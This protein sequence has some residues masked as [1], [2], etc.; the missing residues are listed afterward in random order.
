MQQLIAT[1]SNTHCIRAH[2]CV[3]ECTHTHMHT[4][5]HTHR[6]GD[7]KVK[8]HYTRML[9]LLCNVFGLLDTA[10]VPIPM[11]P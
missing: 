11:A 9:K 4:R 3:Y 8:G 2:A 6:A 1:Y 5:V 10:L 7:G